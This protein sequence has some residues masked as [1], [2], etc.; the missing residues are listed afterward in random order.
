M[1]VM[2]IAFA[3]NLLYIVFGWK[4]KILHNDYNTTIKRDESSNIIHTTKTR[5]LSG[6]IIV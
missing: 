5:E 2:Y 4:K 6:E 3:E 1:F